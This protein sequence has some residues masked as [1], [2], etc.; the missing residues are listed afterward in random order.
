MNI[1]LLVPKGSNKKEKFKQE[2][3]AAKNIKSKQ[4]RESIIKGLNKILLNYEDGKAFYWINDEF[5]SF[6]YNGDAFLYLCGKEI[7]VPTVD[8]TS[9]GFVVMD[10]RDCSMYELR[11]KK[12]VL[13]WRGTSNVPGKFKAG[14]QSSERFRRLREGEINLWYK[15]IAEKM[16]EYWLYKG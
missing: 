8:K 13:L 14:G 4:V 16:K 9:Y 3:A 6:D 7:S 15:K 11:G 10:L 2:I 12:K 5:F 1:S